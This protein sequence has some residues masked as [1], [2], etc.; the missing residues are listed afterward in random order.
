[1]CVVCLS[2]C[3]FLSLC[4]CSFVCVVFCVSVS[5]LCVSVCVCVLVACFGLLRRLEG[6]PFIGLFVLL[7]CLVVS[8]LL[9]VC[10]GVRFVCV[11]V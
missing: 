7:V 11:F 2:A 3:L 8:S 6:C 9:I 5:R 4:V 1:M 10:C